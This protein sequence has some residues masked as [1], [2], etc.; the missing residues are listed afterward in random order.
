LRD[1][2]TVFSAN[3]NGTRLITKS[4]NSKSI[5]KVTCRY[6]ATSVL[7]VATIGEEKSIEN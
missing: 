5:R 4:N 3:N 6:L 7:G 1:Y 2:Y